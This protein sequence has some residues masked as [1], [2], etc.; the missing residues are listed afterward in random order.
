[1]TTRTEPS[2]G[3]SLVVFSLEPWGTVRRRI[4]ILVDELVALEPRMQVLFVAPAFD[5]PYEIRRGVLRP[6]PGPRLEQV[7]PQVHVLRPRKWLPRSLG[8]ASDRL[9]GSQAARAADQVGLREPLLWVNDAAYA[10]FSVASGWPII[11]DVTDDWLLAPLAP[12]QRDRLRADDALLVER[13]DAVV[14][15]SPDLARSRGSSRTVD[16]IPNGVDLERFR[17]T[18]PRPADLPEGPVALYVGTLHEERID[19][20]LL[21]DL[22]RA[23]PDVQIVLVGPDNLP[24]AESARLAATPSVHLLGA[25]PYDQV[26]AYLQHADV[27]IVP[28]QVNPFT[29]SLDPIKAYECLAAGRPTVATPVAGFRGLRPPV[30]IAPRETFVEATGSALAEGAPPPGTAGEGALVP[31]WRE[32]AEAMDAV[33]AR[34]REQ[35]CVR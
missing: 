18:Y 1:M 11:Y 10:R 30:V 22:A 15:C 14:V 29:E 2:P 4:R 31:T 12:R 33:M 25:R 20:G 27:V 9:L 6:R 13:S 26:P 19:L 21:G 8:T 24:A 5:V 16:V 7:H 3:P 35:R 34:V 32:R 28:H 17:R 23:R